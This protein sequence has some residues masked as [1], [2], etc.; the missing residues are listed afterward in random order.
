MDTIDTQHMMKLV[1]KV[2]PTNT[3]LLDVREPHEWAQG[4]I[5]GSVCISLPMLPLR[6]QELDPSKQYILICRS[7][8]R[9]AQAG[10]FL[11]SKGFL[12][13]T[14]YEDG[15]FGWKDMGCPIFIPSN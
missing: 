3:I 8:N 10:Y 7:G 4:I 13:L 9:S 11:E 12:R 15:M 5:E 6:F 1:D 14:N 2:I